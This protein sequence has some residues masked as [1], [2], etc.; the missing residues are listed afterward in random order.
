M[1]KRTIK[2]TDEPMGELKVIPDFFPKPKDLVFK[3][4]TLKVTLLLNKESSFFSKKI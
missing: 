2:Y 3:E 1:K 4:E